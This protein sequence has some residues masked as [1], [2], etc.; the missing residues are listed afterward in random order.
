MYHLH[1]HRQ[2][3]CYTPQ[4]PSSYIV[5]TKAGAVYRLEGRVRAKDASGRGYDTLGALHWRLVS[6]RQH[7]QQ[8]HCIAEQGRDNTF[9]WQIDEVRTS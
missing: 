4:L 5:R 7:L 2:E 3:V 9:I 6:I 1:R 8:A